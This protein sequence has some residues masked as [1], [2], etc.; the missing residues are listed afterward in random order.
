MS[1]RSSPELEGTPDAP[2]T[3]PPLD[4][5]SP[6]PP[7]RDEY[8][9]VSTSNMDEHPEQSSDEEWNE[10]DLPEIVDTRTPAAPPVREP[11]LSQADEIEFNNVLGV[12]KNMGPLKFALAVFGPDLNGFFSFHFK[13]MGDINE[14]SWECNKTIADLRRLGERIQKDKN[15]R[16][17]GTSVPPLP[18]KKHSVFS[19][20]EQRDMVTEFVRAMFTNIVFLGYPWVLSTFEVPGIVRTRID[21]FAKLYQTPLFSSWLNK[22]GGNYKNWKR[23]WVVLYPDF[24]LRYY[25]NQ[26]EETKGG[27]GFRGMVDIQAL[28][29]INHHKIDAT[30]KHIFVLILKH[31]WRKK[32]HPRD[33]KF[34]TSDSSLHNIWVRAVTLLTDGELSKYIPEVTG[35]DAETLRGIE[36]KRMLQRSPSALILAQEKLSN[37]RLLAKLGEMRLEQDNFTAI[38]KVAKQEFDREQQKLEDDWNKL[39]PNLEDARMA[40]TAG[41]E[42]IHNLKQE[43]KAATEICMKE[44]EKAENLVQNALRKYNLRTGI[45]PVPFIPRKGGKRKNTIVENTAPSAFCGQLDMYSSP[46]VVRRRDIWFVMIDGS[47][48][49][50]WTD[51]SEGLDS[52]S[53]TRMQIAEVFYGDDEVGDDRSFTVRSEKRKKQVRL[54]CISEEECQKWVRTIKNGLGLPDSSSED[55]KE[56]LKEEKYPDNCDLFAP[57]IDTAGDVFPLEEKKSKNNLEHNP[58]RGAGKLPG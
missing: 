53:A 52:D 56:D 20:L 32:K 13:Q 38:D 25:D 28:E 50:E 18:E 4:L 42:S 19:F 51:L 33:Y 6:Y 12:L 9:R 54:V 46:T 23:R 3:A 26:N 57:H 49:L 39:M 35:L 17:L 58:S 47:P 8:K 10:N 45:N 36:E 40:F 11:V 2:S 55:E 5:A 29:R 44:M 31:S 14:C 24:T 22:E 16:G 27:K 7:N 15:V 41:Q 1:R 37:V 30:K 48:F 43:L 21:T 34:E